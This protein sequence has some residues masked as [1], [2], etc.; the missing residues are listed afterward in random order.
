MF[1]SVKVFPVICFSFKYS[2]ALIGTLIIS[3]LGGERTVDLS[4]TT[5]AAS[6]RSNTT[7]MK[8]VRP[9]NS[10]AGVR[11]NGFP[12]DVDES[13]L[14]RYSASRGPAINAKIAI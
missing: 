13:Q 6:G 1:G 8:M 2:T 5:K 9:F 12:K 3:C 10:K 7:A 4:L 11:A 14:C